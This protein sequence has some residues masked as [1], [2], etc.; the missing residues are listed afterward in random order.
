MPSR[1]SAN[2]QL[3]ALLIAADYYLSNL[4]PEGSYPSLQGC[5]RDIQHVEL[6]L[7]SRLGLANA[8]LIKLTASNV[9]GSSKPVEPVEEWPTYV[10]MVNGFKTL[11]ARAQPGDQAYIHYSGHGG[12]TP[13]VIPWEKGPRALD[14]SLVPIDIGD[15]SARYL[16]DIELGKLL[17]DMA[18]K[19]I[20]VTI[21]LDS[22]HS[23]GATRGP[24]ATVRGVEWVDKTAR[25]SESLVASVE[26]LAA[27]WHEL[28]GGVP[29]STRSLATA[30]AP[31]GYT[32][33]AACRP[34][35]SAYEYA[36]DGQERNGALT[37]WLLQALQ[38]IGPDL[39]WQMVYAFVLAKV[40]SQ[41]E[42]QT[43]LL[44]GDPGQVVFSGARVQT[45]FTTRVMAVDLPA[46]R[47][48]LG[49]GQAVG[50]RKGGQFVIYPR[51]VIDLS[52]SEAR[53]GLVEV[54][55]L[56]ATESGAKLLQSFGDQKIEA[57]DQALLVGAP[58]VKLVRHVRLIR[59]DGS[60]TSRADT[61]LEAMKRA[62]PG[63]GWVELTEAINQPA[64]F[65]VTVSQNGQF[66]ELCDRAGQ[67]INVQP[68]LRVSD[69]DSVALLVR[70]LVHLTKYQA[71]Q[72]LGNNDP[73]SPLNGKLIVELLALP[74]DFDPTDRPDPKPYAT[75]GAP[76]TLKPEQWTCL[77]V[78]NKSNHVLNLT[79]LDL[80]PDWRI[81]QVFPFDGNLDF[82]P[83][84]PHGE[85][86]IVPLKASLPK[87]YDR[88]IDRLKVLATLGAASFLPLTLPSLDQR[89]ERRGFRN[90]RRAA[91]ALEEL[92]AAVGAE[93]PTLR[94]LMPS[95]SPSQQWTAVEVEVH[96]QT[97]KP[98]ANVT[99]LANEHATRAEKRAGIEE[100]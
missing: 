86:L 64:D 41:F 30:G 5:V 82:E 28:V 11:T 13:T 100:P 14:E 15:S 78:T 59:P 23:G 63:N 8:N 19:G 49:T 40:H 77:R 73:S 18:A 96:I 51:T 4:L 39:T 43:P 48:T 20:M 16:R 17:K 34:A 7:K 58:S 69:A 91:N 72:E 32:L 25:P 46:Q 60:A 3:H 31:Q 84:D 37:Y 62:L 56:G 99:T 74:D 55:Q 89:L 21:V 85:P 90:A 95:A 52:R 35:E 76:V 92:L 22:C 65:T 98:K 38:Q 47:V 67:P 44:Q 12:R 10:N 33:F 81:I 79:V 75:A 50:M 71:V 61:A 29:A 66:Y 54:D 97:D 57:G 9:K 2:G 6:F 94:A 45:Q 83:F 88:G 53:T 36:F 70:R 42:R 27:V 24:D 93:K 26:T 80:Q 87:G 68:A 1:A